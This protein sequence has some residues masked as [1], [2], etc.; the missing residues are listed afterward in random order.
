[1]PLA[2]IACAESEIPTALARWCAAADGSDPETAGT[3]AEG[4]VHL[5]IA[6]ESYHPRQLWLAERAKE[7]LVGVAFYTVDASCV[8]PVNTFRGGRGTAPM[9]PPAV[10]TTGASKVF[11]RE[12]FRKVQV[13][14]I[15]LG[16]GRPIYRRVRIRSVPQEVLMDTLACHAVRCFLRTALCNR[17]VCEAGI[18]VTRYRNVIFSSTVFL[19]R[20]TSC[21]SPSKI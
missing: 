12:E 5:A 1:M 15:Y 20:T 21:Q 19:D 10:T 6:D 16:S 13:S 14:R 2:A 11:S 7:A 9:T 4:R 8:C 3:P 17:C 18:I